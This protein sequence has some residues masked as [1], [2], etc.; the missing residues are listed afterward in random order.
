MSLFFNNLV[1]FCYTVDQYIPIPTFI[2]RLEIIKYKIMIIKNK[3]NIILKK[4]YLLYSKYNNIIIIDC[5]LY[6]FFNI[7]IIIIIK[8][9]NKIK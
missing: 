7:I 4:K 5:Y 8:L 2:V 3:F 6:I 9:I 1:Y